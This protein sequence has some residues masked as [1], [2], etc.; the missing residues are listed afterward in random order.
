MAGILIKASGFILVIM[1]GIL[2]RY[3]GVCTKE[4][5]KFLSS[6]V[7]NITLPCS[8]MA[9]AKNLELTPIM[10]A[11]L[12]IGIGANFITNFVG[13]AASKGKMP[14]ERALYMINTSG[15]NIGA[16]AMPFLQSFF[17]PEYIIYICMFDMGNSFMCLG[18]TYAF[19]ST[20]ASADDRPTVIGVIKKLFSSIPFCTYV[21]LLILALFKLSVPAP[22]LTMTE[23]AAKANPF[24]AM[25][26][27]GVLLD[28]KLDL[29]EIAALKKILAGRYI[30]AIT[31]SIL[32]YVFL[33]VKVIVKKMLIIAFFAPVSAAAP[34]FSAR[35]GSKSPVPAA[36]NSLSIVISIVVITSMILF[37]I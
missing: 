25:L 20:V 2:L 24:L 28:L 9:S 7:L 23:I 5:G 8:I 26:V 16:F 6:V 33:P 3:K 34:L 22:I 21:I 17:E 35:L 11:M 29:T 30:V 10:L 18:G 13:Y 1:A 12:F 31:L 37:F 27:I 14:T 4:H 32:V 19:A 36:V 15:F